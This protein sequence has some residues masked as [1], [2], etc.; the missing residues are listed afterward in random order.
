MFSFPVSAREYF[1]SFSVS[2][3]AHS[4]FSNELFHPREFVRMP[5]I[6]L[7]SSV[8]VLWKNCKQLTI[9]ERRR[10]GLPG[11]ESF[12]CLLYWLVLR[13]LDTASVI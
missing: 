9:V 7:P 12:D 3:A 6:C 10:L 4:S 11:D 13:Q 5:E 8:Y 1:L 2:S